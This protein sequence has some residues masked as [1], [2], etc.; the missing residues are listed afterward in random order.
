MNNVF[1]SR[2]SFDSYAYG[3]S[4]ASV[5]NSTKRRSRG[6]I[7]GRIAPQLLSPDSAP[8]W[9][10]IILCVWL[11]RQN[12][13]AQ[14]LLSQSTHA[15]V[16]IALIISPAEIYK[17]YNGDFMINYYVHSIKLQRYASMDL[18][19]LSG[20][21]KSRDYP[22][23]LF[24]SWILSRWIEPS[25]YNNTLIRVLSLTLKALTEHIRRHRSYS[26]AWQGPWNCGW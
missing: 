16:T 15:S 9:L 24:T 10:C 8:R 18:Y 7:A 22:C 12:V 2:P 6:A 20:I 3:I 4:H 21:Y 14:R 19:D 11:C 25:S 26:N 5:F 1:L 13:Y 17:S 23:D